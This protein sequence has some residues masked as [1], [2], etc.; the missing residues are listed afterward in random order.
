MTTVVQ[1]V[2]SMTLSIAT[3]MKRMLPAPTE[4]FLM[5]MSGVRL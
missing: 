3:E 5:G 2:G 4:R 1:R